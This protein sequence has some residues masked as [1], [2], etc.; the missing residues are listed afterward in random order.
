MC[1]IFFETT[2]SGLR[3]RT[4]TAQLKTFGNDA[5]YDSVII[6]NTKYYKL[7]I[8]HRTK[9]ADTL[10]VKDSLAK[11]LQKSITV[12]VDTAR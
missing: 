9:L 10:I 2:A 12:Q 5:A 6:N 3:A 1:A 8:L 7:Y 4:R 11:F